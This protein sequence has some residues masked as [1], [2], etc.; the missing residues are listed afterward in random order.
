VLVEE[1]INFALAALFNILFAGVTF[2]L[3]GLAVAWSRT[4]PRWLGWIVVLAGARFGRRRPDP[5]RGR[6]AHHGDLGP[7]HH[8]PHRDHP[9]VGGDEYAGPPQGTRAGTRHHPDP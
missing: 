1:T 2:I 4:Y 7:H 9:V 5:G 8:L 3:Y 6:R